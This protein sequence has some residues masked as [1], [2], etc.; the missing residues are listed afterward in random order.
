L[1]SRSYFFREDFYQTDRRS[2]SCP[3]ERLTV[4]DYQLCDQIG[5]PFMATH[6]EKSGWSENFYDDVMR[7]REVREIAL[8]SSFVV[9]Y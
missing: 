3:G 8:R 9:C 6:A 7:I 5:Q 2:P 4:F 1:Q